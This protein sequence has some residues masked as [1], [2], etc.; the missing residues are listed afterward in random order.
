MLVQLN[1]KISEMFDILLVCILRLGQPVSRHTMRNHIISKMYFCHR[2]APGVSER[3]WG[4]NLDASIAGEYET[5]GGHSCWPSDYLGVPVTSLGV[6]MTSL[7]APGSTGDK[8][9][10]AG[11]KS[12]RA[13]NY[14]RAVWE[15]QHLL[16]QCCWCAPGNHSYYLSFND[17]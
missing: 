17:F 16:W 3:M 6:P 5:L 14:C 11:D 15:I 9:G 4:V 12:G 10:S 7:G 2:K 1:N 13:S 8:P